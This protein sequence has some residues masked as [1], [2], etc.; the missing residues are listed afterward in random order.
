L[1]PLAPRF[2]P[3]GMLSLMRDSP[4]QKPPAKSEMFDPELMPFVASLRAVPVVRGEERSY[5][6]VTCCFR[7]IPG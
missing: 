4:G 1:V 6:Y 5:F 7:V 3:G 2:A